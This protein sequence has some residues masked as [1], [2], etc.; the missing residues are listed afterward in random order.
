MLAPPPLKKSSSGKFPFEAA[1]F[2]YS[3]R[4]HEL[5]QLSMEIVFFFTMGLNLFEAAANN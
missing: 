4:G 5:Y 3:L 1:G 2:F